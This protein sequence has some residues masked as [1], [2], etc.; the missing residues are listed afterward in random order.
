MKVR[1]FE[2]VQAMPV[3]HTHYRPADKWSAFRESADSGQNKHTPSNATN[4]IGLALLALIFLL[5]QRGRHVHGPQ[6]ARAKR[7]AHSS[8][9][10]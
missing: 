2:S 1:L 10:G 5:S 4:L 7:R 3:Y 9:D 8:K 6:E